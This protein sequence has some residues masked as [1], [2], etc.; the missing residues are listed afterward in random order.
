[1]ISREINSDLLIDRIRE[2]PSGDN[3][4]IVIASAYLLKVRGDYGVR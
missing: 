1:M 4:P 3:W 2:R